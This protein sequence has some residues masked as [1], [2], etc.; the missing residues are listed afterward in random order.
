MP[1]A[2]RR[3]LRQEVTDRLI[4]LMEQGVAPWQKPWDPEKS[5]SL[6]PI[7]PTTEKA[8]RGGNA[9]H[10]FA[11]QNVRGYED[12]RWMTYRQ[13]TEQGWQ[14]RKGEKGTQIEFWKFPTEEQREEAFA[15][16]KKEPMPLQQLY[17]VFNG[18]Q[19]EGIPALQRQVKPE[20]EVVQAAQS[21]LDASGA[22]VLHDQQDRA[23]YRRSTDSIHLP[24]E[25]AFATPADYYGT[26]LHELAHWS[27]HPDRLN[28]ETLAAS[29][30]FGD[31][32]YAREELRAEIASMFLAAEKGI[33]H[34]PEQHAAYVSSWVATLQKDKNEI[35]RAAKDAS[36]ISD[37]LQGLEQ[38]RTRAQQDHIQ[39]FESPTVE[40]SEYVAR[41]D[42]ENGAVAVVEKNTATELRDIV[43]VTEIRNDAATLET[44]EIRDNYVDGRQAL[45]ATVRGALPAARMQD[46]DRMSGTYAGQILEAS[47][48]LAAQRISNDLVVI[49]QVTDLDREPH[50][51]DE[52]RIQ[53]DRGQAS[54]ADLVAQH[55]KAQERELAL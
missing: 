19:I 23:F 46:A 37:F 18:S 29:Y 3:D 9:L 33:P 38:E 34:H 50:P 35:F 41:F 51:G 12:P 26:A 54:V 55:G 20:W 14:V 32:A 45:E 30:R 25:A 22:R 5:G 21:I 24:N 7:N 48:E 17:T 1:M 31:P 36:E 44:E 40:T 8:Y 49:H 2:E 28:R 13:A 43:G 52:V 39:S 4:S 10:L 15:E 16:G 27:G 11:E 42:A 6:L 47:S 53:Y